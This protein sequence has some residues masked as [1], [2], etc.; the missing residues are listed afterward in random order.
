MTKVDFYILPENSQA[1]IFTC[2]LVEKA[3]LKKHQVYLHA[4][5]DTEAR[6]LDDILWTF[7]PGSFVPHSRYTGKSEPG[8]TPVLI[9][10]EGEQA[11]PPDTHDVLINLSPNVPL[12]F[13][14]FE[15]V[16]ELVCGDNSQ[17]AQA[18]ERYRFYK[19]RGYE[20]KTHEIKP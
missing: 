12:F 6:K 1:E 8:P 16:A 3:Y 15:R 19:D 4:R 20:L 10:N 13:S 7:R 11:P 5:D 14:Q 2:K 18:R 17:R 9:G